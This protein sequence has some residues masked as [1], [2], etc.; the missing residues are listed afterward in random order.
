M[1][2]NVGQ[3]RHPRLYQ[4]LANGKGNGARL[5]AE[6]EQ[7]HHVIF[8]RRP[9][10]QMP[11]SQGER[12]GVHHNCPNP[13]PFPAGFGQILAVAG[14]TIAPVFH[15]NQLAIYPGDL[16]ESQIRQK[17]R[18][19]DLGIEKEPEISPHGL[20]LCQVADN[21]VQQPLSLMTAGNRQTAQGILKAAS[22][23]NQSP[24]IV[25]YAAGVVQIAVQADAFL[26]QQG[27]HLGHVPAF[28]RNGFY[29]IAHQ[30]FLLP[31]YVMPDAKLRTESV[32]RRS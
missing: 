2:H 24:V 18:C 31:A 13:F 19:F 16:I 12:I 30:V 1:A 25:K 3:I 23:G 7:V 9:L 17:F 21:A 10:H 5:L 28:G 14:K 15:E 6:Y 8:R 11:V 29:Y 22:C 20:V 26:L 4:L 27:F 32:R